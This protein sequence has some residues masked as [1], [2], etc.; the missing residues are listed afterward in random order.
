MWEARFKWSRGMPHAR[1][2]YADDD[3]ALR[4]VV[5]ETLELEG[6]SVVTCVDGAAALALIE[7]REHFDLLL[8]D[9]SMPCV[10]GIELTRRARV[11]A[12]RRSTPVIIFSAT[13]CRSEACGAG[14]DRFLR[15]PDGIGLIVE[16]VALLLAA[17]ARA[18]ARADD[19]AV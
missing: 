18:Q 4:R 1:I 3:R 19:A 15:K 11:I 13:D 17:S 12:H 9:N 2:L 6:W 14:A 10:S 7:G 8:L 5:R 16:A